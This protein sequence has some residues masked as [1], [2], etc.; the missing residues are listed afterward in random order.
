V[1]RIE[2]ATGMNAVQHAIE[3]DRELARVA[4]LLKASPRDTYEKVD[5]LIAQRKE[6]QREIEQ[7]KRKLVSGGAGDL[8]ASARK[9][10]DVTVLGTTVDV[11]DPGALRELA[12]K[13]R[14]KLAPAVIVLGA[15]AA[16]D[17]VVLVC[18]VSKELTQRFKAGALI[19]EVAAIAGGSG[20]GRPD[21]AQAGGT[22]PD[23][24]EA[25]VAKVYELVGGV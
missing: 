9:Q 5:R 4:D 12:D 1:R 19:K 6:L 17:K 14:D 13:L 20:G 2:A 18:T 7:L 11:A 25:A 22:Q 8:T 15:K 23:K 24:L 16:D 10:G 3:V 21:F